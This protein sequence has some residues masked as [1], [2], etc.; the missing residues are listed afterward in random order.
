MSEKD[1]E[2]GCWCWVAGVADELIADELAVGGIVYDMTD[3]ADPETGEVT[4]TYHL[5]ASYRGQVRW[6]ALRASQVGEVGLP[7]TA[8]IRSTVRALCRQIAGGRGAFTSGDVKALDV[9]R[10]LT[11]LCT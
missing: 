6:H 11:S 10:R 4:R 3:I 9:A 5:V 8:T 1:V 2:L 7:N